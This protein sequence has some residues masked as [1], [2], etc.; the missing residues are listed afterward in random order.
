MCL[1]KLVFIFLSRSKRL[2]IVLASVQI[3]KHHWGKGGKVCRKSPQIWPGPFNPNFLAMSQ[4]IDRNVIM[5]LKELAKTIFWWFLDNKNVNT[6]TSS[7]SI[8][9]TDK[10]LQSWFGDSSIIKWTSEKFLEVKIDSSWQSTLKFHECLKTIAYAVCSKAI[11]QG[12]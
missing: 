12:D 4:C 9:S 3:Y 10:Q 8:M 5:S 6:D 1:V 7:H 11:I 2:Y